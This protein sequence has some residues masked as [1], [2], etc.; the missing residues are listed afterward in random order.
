EIFLHSIKNNRELIEFI[1]NITGGDIRLALTLVGNFFASGHVDMQKILDRDAE[2]GPYVI[3]MHEFMR[4]VLYG[5]AI[6]YNPARS[7]IANIF[8]VEFNTS[9]DHFTLP[10]LIGTLATLSDSGQDGFVETNEIY[11][12]M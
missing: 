12:Q 8:D 10:F 1:E 7:A 6:H 11:Q 3:P 2:D 4:A 9:Q 5:D